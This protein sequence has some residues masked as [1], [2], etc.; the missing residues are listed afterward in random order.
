MNS[1]TST[2]NNLFKK[3][4]YNLYSIDAMKNSTTENNYNQSQIHSQSQNQ[5]NPNQEKISTSPKR[6]TGFSELLKT[7]R[8][9]SKL[10]FMINNSINPYKNADMVKNKF[11]KFN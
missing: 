7:S 4:K 9:L 10:P 1:T 5:T 11:K 3:S 6:S 8:V 2:S